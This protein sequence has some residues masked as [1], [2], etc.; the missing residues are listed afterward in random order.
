MAVATTGS[1]RRAGRS[2]N[3]VVIALRAHPGAVDRLAVVQG[4]GTITDGNFL[5][6][7][8]TLENYRGIFETSDC[9]PGR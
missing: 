8:W 4:P 9:S 2:A 1:R 3:I 5:P 7:E 6:R